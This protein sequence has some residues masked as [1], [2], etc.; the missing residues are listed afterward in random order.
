MLSC[1]GSLLDVQT[2]L[3]HLCADVAHTSWC[4]CILGR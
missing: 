3:L 4:R 1:H 2:M